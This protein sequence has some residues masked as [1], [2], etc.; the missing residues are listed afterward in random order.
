MGINMRRK[1]AKM[2]I[3]IN[4]IIVVLLLL[5]SVVNIIAPFFVFPDSKAMKLTYY[6][7]IHRTIKRLLSFILLIIAWK[8]YKRVSA[9]WSAAMLVLSLIIFQYLFLNHNRII[10]LVFLIEV[11][12]YFI[13]MFSKNYYCRRMDKFSI[14]NGI[15]VF[16]LYALFVFFN[17]VISLFKVKGKLTFLQ[18]ME[19]TVEVIF[20]LDTYTPA[21]AV[22][23]SFIFWFSW[24]CIIV[25]LIL[26][27]TPY[28][29]KRTQNKGGMEKAR[30]LVKKYGQNC[31]SYLV[32]EK[33]KSLFWGK[34]VEGVIAYGVVKDTLVV[35][36]DPVCAPEDFLGFLAEIKNFCEKNAYSLLFL[37]TTGMYL[38]QYKKLGLGATKCGVEP[39]FY[40]PEYS[41][42]GGKAAKVRLNINHATKAGISIKEYDPRKSRNTA[43]EKAITEVSQEW[44]AMK[45][46]GELVFTMGAIGFDNPMD[47]RY[48]YAVNPENEVEGFIVFV[49]FHGMSGYMADVTRHRKNATRGVMEKILY[50]AMMTFQEEGV[51]WVS[52]AVAP[53][54]RLEEEPEV[55]EKLFNTIFEKMNSVYGFKALYQTKLK[56]NPTDWEQSYYVYYP[57]IFTP[58]MAYS[59]IKIQNPLGLK[60]YIRSFFRNSH[61]KQEQDNNN[62]LIARQ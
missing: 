60:D 25:G 9:A 21:N 30:Q 17:A 7:E 31:N 20:G 49:P 33:D 3:V 23:H 47:R 55:T 45:K 58:S 35:L 13:L 56:Y 44:F 10:N 53:L 51:E 61:K 14:R 40:L 57:A 22:Y 38:E 15:G 48:F 42:A 62:G 8:L 26:L 28:I 1:L 52:L 4:K 11:L 16:F 27:L 18:C 12:C 24:S 37:N 39:R 36:G 41:L 19:Q 59:I 2:I 34:S 29:S 5:L 6:L 46:S 50:E 54:A 32:L 43:L